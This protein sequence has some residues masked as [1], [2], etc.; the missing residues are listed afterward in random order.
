MKMNSKILLVDSTALTQVLFSSSDEALELSQYIDFEAARATVK[1]LDSS[2]VEARVAAIRRIS[3]YRPSLLEVAIAQMTKTFRQ[4]EAYSTS[5]AELGS[6]SPQ[7]IG[8][9]AAFAEN[10]ANDSNVVNLVAAI[11]AGAYVL[12]SRK[13]SEASAGIS[14]IQ[15]VSKNF[16]VH[17]VR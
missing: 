13:L 14:V 1:I 15:K 2:I 6:C 4:L 8:A 11:Q 5:L 12:S 16:A 3:D 17:G 10:P 7:S 9:I